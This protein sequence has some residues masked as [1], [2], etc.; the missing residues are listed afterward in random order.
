MRAAPSRLR[1]QLDD[2]GP[3]PHYCEAP[4]DGST[5]EG[6]ELDQHILR[7]GSFWDDWQSTSERY[8]VASI[9]GTPTTGWGFIKT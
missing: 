9:S 7:G 6:G 4:T 5:W 2:L 3:R 8:R 1:N